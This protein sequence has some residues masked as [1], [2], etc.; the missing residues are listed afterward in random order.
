MIG[1]DWM[2]RAAC[3]NRDPE[4]WFPPKSGNPNPA[5]NICRQC[6]VITECAQYALQT[7]QSHG[8]VAGTSAASATGRRKLHLLA[9]IEREPRELKYCQGPC[10][11]PLRD[12]NTPSCNAP[13]TVR[14]GRLGMCDTC[15]AAHKRGYRRHPLKVGA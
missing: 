2:P 15:A 8:I 5:I 14:E 3:R 6:P 4:L 9:G 7:G 13:G 12:R 1:R 11:R 10:G